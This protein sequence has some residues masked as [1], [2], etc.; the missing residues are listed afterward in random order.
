MVSS[1]NEWILYFAALLVGLW[2]LFQ[3]SAPAFS[4]LYR[5]VNQGQ[6]DILASEA[7]EKDI[8]RLSPMTQEHFLKTFIPFSLAVLGSGFYVFVAFA[9]ALCK[10]LF[11]KCALLAIIWDLISRVGYVFYLSR[12]LPLRSAGQNLMFGLT[13]GLLFLVCGL[14]S[15][16]W[17]AWIK[18]N[19]LP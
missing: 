6:V 4:I 5:Y 18:K 8:P 1:K 9:S 12:F 13:W 2:S 15:L 16:F 7:R 19:A 11:T 10:R 17:L 3:F 14:F